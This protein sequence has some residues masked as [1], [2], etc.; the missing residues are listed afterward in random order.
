[1]VHQRRVEELI[2]PDTGIGRT[3]D[4][5]LDAFA[6]K[7][8][9]V[10]DRDTAWAGKVVGVAQ[11][12]RHC[13]S[14]ESQGGTHSLVDLPLEGPLIGCIHSVIDVCLVGVDRGNCTAS[15]MVL[16]HYDC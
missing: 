3:L 8:R 2:D 1:V 7:G 12:I 4:N 11:G 5:S 14:G 13:S 15:Y 16:D 6:V 9:R 10:S